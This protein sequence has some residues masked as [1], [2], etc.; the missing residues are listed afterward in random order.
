MCTALFLASISLL[1]RLSKLAG[2][3]II[4]SCVFLQTLFDEFF[5]AT[6]NV[7]FTS[8]PV[9]ALGIFEQVKLTLPCSGESAH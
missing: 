4:V 7:I 8:M 5:I 6:Y 9:L 2:I 3:T 1:V